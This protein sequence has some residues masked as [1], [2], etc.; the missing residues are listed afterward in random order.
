VNSLDPRVPVVVFVNFLMKKTP[1]L[2]AD[3]IIDAELGCTV[4]RSPQFS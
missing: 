2:L 4:S 1:F 3:I